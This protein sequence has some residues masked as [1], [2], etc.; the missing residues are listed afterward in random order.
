MILPS[1]MSDSAAATH[2][3]ASDAE[4]VLVVD[5]DAGAR[6]VIAR[7][8][9]EG[10]FQ[11]V[12]ARGG[13]EA[14]TRLEDG[15]THITA[16]LTDVSMPDMTGVELAYYVRDHHPTIPV[17]IV[18]GDISELERSVVGRSGVPFIKKPVRAEALHT[19]IR[20]A[21]RQTR[22]SSS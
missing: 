5:D 14:I 11:V 9:E 12:T 1:Q 7:L 2:N 22:D 20:E 21:I 4:T 19:A 6:T 15:T 17:A 3:H 10:G 16:V 8:L 18:S 13:T